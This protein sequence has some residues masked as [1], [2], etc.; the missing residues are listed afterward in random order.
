MRILSSKMHGRLTIKWPT[1]REK[2]RLFDFAAF[3]TASA[4]LRR[5]QMKYNELSP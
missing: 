1:L 3:N 2:Y 5:V 4:T